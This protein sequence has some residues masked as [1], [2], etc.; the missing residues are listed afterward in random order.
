MAIKSN[1]SFRGLQITGAYSRVVGAEIDTQVGATTIKIRD[2]ASKE[3][4]A[5]I[6]DEVRTPLPAPDYDPANPVHIAQWEAAGSPDLAA[7]DAHGEPWRP[8]VAEYSVEY[9]WDGSKTAEP[10]LAERTISLPGELAEAVAQLAVP[11][12]AKADNLASQ[13]YRAAM[14]SGDFVA[15]EAV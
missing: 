15:A 9:R 3:A 8:T 11:G 7:L 1:L 2:W 6:L 12:G 10:A 13:L 14:A 5:K 4:A